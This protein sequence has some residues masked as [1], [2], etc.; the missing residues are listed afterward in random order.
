MRLIDVSTMHLRQFA[1]D[2]IPPYAVLSH[3]WQEGEVTINDLHA[4]YAKYMP[5]FQKIQFLC[6]QAQNDG[7]QF[8][9]CDT[10]CIDKSSS[11]ELSESI[12]SMFKWYLDARICYA[13]LTDV[14]TQATGRFESEFASSRWFRRGWTLQELIAPERVMFYGQGWI[15][16][17]FK[18][19]LKDRIFEI[20]GI[21]TS[22]LNS[23]WIIQRYSIAE[24]ISWASNRRTTRVE[25][26]A[27]SLM[28]I[29]DVHMPLVYGEGRSA[30]RRLQEELIKNSDDE[31]VFMHSGSEILA[32]HPAAFK[33]STR[34]VP[35]K[36]TDFSKPFSLTNRGL[37]IE[38]Q[39]LSRRDE[40][41]P[42]GEPMIYGIFN[43][44]SN[45]DYDNYYAIPLQATASLDTFVR[46]SGL[47]IPIPEAEA[48]HGERRNIY[49]R[50]KQ[51][52]SSN[53][54]YILQCESVQTYGYTSTPY[55]GPYDGSSPLT[56]HEGRHVMTLEFESTSNWSSVSILFDHS[57]T[58][59]AFCC[60]IFFDFQ[61]DKIGAIIRHRSDPFRDEGSEFKDWMSNG[62]PEG[63]SIQLDIDA[64]GHMRRMQA[65]VLTRQEK[66]LKE[67]VL[68]LYVSLHE[69]E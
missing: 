69:L 21:P 27:Y 26:E 66:K 51:P 4:S 47:P 56:W 6:I 29:L 40:G 49:I 19:D 18:S 25:D 37:Q 52:L 16:L 35:L 46:A 48:L 32:H 62:S 45:L 53:I 58:G 44:H 60:L 68:V 65:V 55:D 15:E 13:Y 63:G 1:D 24:R 36:Q 67:T 8:A 50:L 11:E 3:T 61:R 22:V 43:C 9:W 30:F 59:Q 5:G 2:E 7:L 41:N 64:D 17:G 20:T 39:L 23:P 54:S 28:G 33:H 14:S 12:N 31:S 34:I 38:L 10:C 57:R 42:Y